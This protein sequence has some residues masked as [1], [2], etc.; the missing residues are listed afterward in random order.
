MTS[1]ENVIAALPAIEAQYPDVAFNVLNV[2]ADDTK[3]QLY[4]VLQTLIEGIV[5]TGIAMLFFL[6][7]WR[8]ALVVMIAIPASLLRHVLRHEAGA[9]SPSTPSRCWR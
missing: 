6:R 2:Q 3:A 1:S 9:I 7:S 5:F 8:N 4:G